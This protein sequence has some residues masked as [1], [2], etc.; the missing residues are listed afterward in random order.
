MR[1]M[2]DTAILAIDLFGFL[3]IVVV[4]G[5]QIYFDRPGQPNRAESRRA[6]PVTRMRSNIPASTSSA[7]TIK[8]DQQK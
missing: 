7:E 8:D 2:G 3:L 4:F 5:Y 1:V 6:S